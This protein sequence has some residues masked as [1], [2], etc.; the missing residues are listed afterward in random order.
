MSYLRNLQ[1]SV[2]TP[3]L[4]LQANGQLAQKGQCRTWNQSQSQ[5]QV[6]IPSKSKTFCF[7]FYNLN[8][9]KITRSDRIG[10]MMKNCIGSL[11]IP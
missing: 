3:V 7:K 2:D 5:A 4:V 1:T 8:L 11:V 9:H 6:S 10:F